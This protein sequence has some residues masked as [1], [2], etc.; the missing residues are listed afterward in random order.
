[1][2]RRI[3][4]KRRKGEAVA[5]TDLLRAWAHISTPKLEGMIATGDDETETQRVRRR[6]LQLR[7][8]IKE[9]SA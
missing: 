6:V 2:R 8:A 5:D 3:T 1:V 7:Q 9:V 4:F